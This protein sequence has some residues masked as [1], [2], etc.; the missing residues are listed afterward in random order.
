MSVEVDASPEQS[1]PESRLSLDKQYVLVPHT[2]TDEQRRTLLVRYDEDLQKQGLF[3]S[4][5]DVTVVRKHETL[6]DAYPILQ[7]EPW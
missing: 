7:D 5:E 3:I 2:W 6:Y 1:P 4:D